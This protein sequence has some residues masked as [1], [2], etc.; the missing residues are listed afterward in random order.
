MS[1]SSGVQGRTAH[2]GVP[3]V[4]VPV[5]VHLPVKSCALLLVAAA[6]LLGSD[7]QTAFRK[8]HRQAQQLLHKE[9][10]QPYE[11]GREAQ[12]L[13]AAASLAS[14]KALKFYLKCCPLGSG[15][16]ANGGKK[17]SK[18]C[19]SKAWCGCA[20]VPAFQWAFQL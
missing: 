10:K 4:P 14:L 3:V 5:P 16:I 11:G 18:Y 12:Q 8:K 9:L 15:I 7:R 20:V 1:Q 17:I 2:P 13:L 19:I 6:E